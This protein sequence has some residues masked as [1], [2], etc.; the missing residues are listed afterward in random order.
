MKSD[1]LLLI[2]PCLILAG[3]GDVTQAEEPHW[4][5][6]PLPSMRQ[7]A[8][9]TIDDNINERLAE[10]QLPT[11]KP[12]LAHRQIR[13]LSLMLTGLPPEPTMVKAFVEQ[14]TDNHYARLVDR[15]LQS[16]RFGERWAR[17]WMDAVSYTHLRA[18]EK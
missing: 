6:Q 7:L 5:L 13:R 2:G 14:P 4:S 17:H 16:P 8:G 15:Y 9:T 10:H 11:A 18:H 3:F 1:F 12:A